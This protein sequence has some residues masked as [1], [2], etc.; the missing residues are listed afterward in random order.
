MSEK[1]TLNY[2]DIRCNLRYRSL[3]SEI[4]NT[5]LSFQELRL[6]FTIMSHFR[7]QYKKCIVEIQI[8]QI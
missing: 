7:V 8:S 6:L 5:Q 2:I 4:E 3:K 1:D